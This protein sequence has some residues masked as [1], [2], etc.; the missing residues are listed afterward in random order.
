MW[1]CLFI[2]AAD[3]HYNYD[4]LSETDKH[5]EIHIAKHRNTSTGKVELFFDEN[6]VSFKNLDKPARSAA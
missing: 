4:D 5:R 1:L 2:K 3:R 6:T